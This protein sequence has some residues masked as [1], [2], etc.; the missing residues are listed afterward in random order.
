ML[1]LTRRLFAWA[2]S[3][4]TADFYERALY[5][6]IL[7]S[8]EPRSGMM[9]YLCSLK[10]G[11]FKVFNSPYDSFWCCTGTGM[12]NHAKYG[13]SIYFQD[14][15][16]LFVNLFIAS[17]LDWKEKGLKIRQETKFPEEPVT[18]F[19]FSGSKPA[20]A[21]IRIRHP[22]WAESALQISV[23]G[24]PLTVPS[25][26]GEYAVVSRKWKSG[27]TL[28][29]TFPMRLH[30]ETL[31]NTPD[32]VAVLYGPVVLAGALG[33]EGMEFPMPFA[34]ERMAYDT[35]PTPEVPVIVADDRDAS[36]WLRPV[37][38]KPLTF[39]A[40]RDDLFRTV[41]GAKRATPL[42][43][44]PFYDIWDE[45]YTVYWHAFTADGW[46]QKESEFRKEQDRVK[47]LESRLTDEFR[48][49]EM[50]PER[51]H[52]FKGERSTTG[53]LDLRKYRD[54]NRGGWFSFEMKVDGM[55]PMELVCT[56][57]GDHT[58]RN[59][60]ILVDDRVIATQALKQEKP[61]EFF[62]V[63]YPIPADVT[64]G[65][66]K[67]TVKFQAAQQGRGAGPLFKTHALRVQ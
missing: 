2:P 22:W 27:D 8:Q 51:E 56:Y 60:D 48:P 31:P 59:F 7:A 63:T 62:E 25:K 12:E 49:G 17:E 42:Q 4:K 3:A 6:H 32:R 9:I 33:Q 1:R 20:D 29:V 26:P 54:A 28:E 47:A 5:N 10:P 21:A 34:K 16:G 24:K 64:K 36:K 14:A 44:R 46:K 40:T 38:G 67:V 37:A 52:N 19:V 39:A 15:D 50:Q 55:R 18:Q 23:N 66:E 58:N 41:S 43:L 61:G 35:A 45:R 13:D 30:I 11:H 53:E 65:K 57:W